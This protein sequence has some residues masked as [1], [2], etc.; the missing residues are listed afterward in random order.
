MTN[1]K[2][3]I[4]HGAYS[5][6]NCEL[7]GLNLIYYNRQSLIQNHE[8]EAFSPSFWIILRNDRCDS[9]SVWRTHAQRNIES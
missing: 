4:I 7:W 8:N 5:Y 1:Y 9:W 3:S 6:L 2:L